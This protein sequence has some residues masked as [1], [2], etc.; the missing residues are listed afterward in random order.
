MVSSVVRVKVYVYDEFEEDLRKTKEWTLI[1]GFPGFGYV[2]T[3]ATR[4]L[5]SK[6]NAVKIGDVL[7]KYM[8]DFTALEDYGLMTPYE[9]FMV[10]EKKLLILVN[11]ALPQP[12]ERLAYALNFVEWFKEIG[13]SRA[14][15]AGG[16][17]IK[18]K[19]GEEEFR[20]IATEGCEW[21]FSEPQ[22]DKGLYI[23]GPLA[24]FLIALKLKKVPTLVV[25]PYTEP[26]KYNPRAAA[27]F[28]KKVNEILDLS[29]DVA[30]L[31]QYSKLVEEAEATLK[32][33]MKAAREE[34]GPKPYM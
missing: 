18:Y 13:G 27:V 33:A 15:L 29:V 30:D 23:V 5:V 25:L 19:V 7:T 14:I 34:R 24:L 2:G 17:N 9:V 4:Y 1:T 12:P 22:I 32:E 31:L 10:K 11:N 6:L 16:L 20:W 3:I 8:P 26:S 21:R 28:I